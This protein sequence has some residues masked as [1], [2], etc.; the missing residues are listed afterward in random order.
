[1]RK[2]MI[3]VIA[4]ALTSSLLQGCAST[5]EQVFRG[6]QPTIK[7]VYDKKMNGGESTQINI[8]KRLLEPTADEME[9][10]TR[11]S[12]NELMVTFPLLPNPMLYMYVD[13]HISAGGLPIPAYVTQFRLYKSDY[14]ALPGE[15]GGWQ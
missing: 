2:E 12:M 4:S 5:K 14:Y 8:K 1:M 7:E 11:E 6:D 15:I 9:A 10:Y 3:L 13:P